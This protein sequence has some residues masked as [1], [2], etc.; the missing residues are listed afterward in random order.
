MDTAKR[1]FHSAVVGGPF[2]IL[3]HSQWFPQF[4]G[5]VLRHRYIYGLLNGKPQKLGRTALILKPFAG[6]FL[7]S[8]R[9]DGLFQAVAVVGSGVGSERVF[10]VLVPIQSCFHGRKVA[11][12]EV[13]SKIRIFIILIKIRKILIKTAYFPLFHCHAKQ[14][15]GDCLRH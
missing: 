14:H 15:D 10:I 9:M 11:Q 7:K 1:F 8:L 4:F 12:G 6:G 5:Q 3:F 2:G 13:S